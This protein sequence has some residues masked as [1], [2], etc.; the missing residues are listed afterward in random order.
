MKG[1]IKTKEYGFLESKEK[2]RYWR[3]ISSQY[4]WLLDEGDWLHRLVWYLLTS[5]M[6]FPLI[7]IAKFYSLKSHKKMLENVERNNDILP[8]RDF[9]DIYPG[10]VYSPLIKAYELKFF[11]DCKLD[12]P[13]LEIGMGDGY[14]SSLLFKSKGM[15]LSIGAD[16][17]YDVVKIAREYG[18]CERVIIMD[19][20]EI[21]LPDN[22]IGTIL[23]NNLMHHLP[24]RTLALRELLRVLKKG[25]RLIFTD[26]IIGWGIY[27]WEQVLLRKISLD[28]L[29]KGILDF[30]LRFFIQNLLV[31][32][33]F[34]EKKSKDL[35]FKIIKKVGFISKASMYISSLFE[36]LNL[37]QGQPTRFQMVSWLNTL[38]IS[39]VLSRYMADIIEFCYWLDKKHADEYAFIFIELEKFKED[40][41]AIERESEFITIV[42][43]QCKKEL[44]NIND[45]CL[46]CNEC[47]VSYPIIDGIPVLL[48]YSKKLRNYAYFLKDRGSLK[49]HKT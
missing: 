8:Y 28:S 32:E 40:N 37:K 11:R 41:V 24:N 46:F 9:V 48:S 2:N 23:M 29:A 16:F 27:T 18:H 47:G 25:G 4:D 12:T 42:C 30:K 38:G 17:M 19:A 22:S 13:V 45:E 7:F 6:V 3:K 43:P 14:F 20:L 10:C 36:F 5:I 15:K 33:Y 1:F 34:Y 31:D 49:K 44:N 35:D 21:P 39:N 26:N